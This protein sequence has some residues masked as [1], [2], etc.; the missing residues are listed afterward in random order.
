MYLLLLIFHVYNYVHIY[1]E[2]AL[3]IRDKNKEVLIFSTNTAFLKKFY[4]I[5]FYSG[6]G[7]MQIIIKNS[8]VN[9][10]Q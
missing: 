5:N 8:A 4:Y 9:I 10:K 1:I 6:Q 2:F 7:A 3:T